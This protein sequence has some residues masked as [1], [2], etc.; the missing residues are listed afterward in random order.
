SVFVDARLDRGNFAILSGHWPELQR[1]LRDQGIWLGNIQ[2]DSTRS[3]QQG[4]RSSR[5]GA[6]G[7][8]LQERQGREFGD[9]WNTSDAQLVAGTKI[10]PNKATQVRATQ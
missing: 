2:C 5:Q 4:E 9:R 6:F 8:N 3:D 1:D 7:E 10:Q